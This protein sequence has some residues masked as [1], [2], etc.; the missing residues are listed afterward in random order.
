MAG[1]DMGWPLGQEEELQDWSDANPQLSL[2]CFR[3]GLK[4]VTV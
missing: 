2:K 4:K 1:G 3:I